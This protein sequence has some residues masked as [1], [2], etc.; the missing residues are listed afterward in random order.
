MFDGWWTVLW[1][2][3]ASRS[4]FTLQSCWPVDN[5]S[6]GCREKHLE[7]ANKITCELIAIPFCSFFGDDLKN[8][9]LAP[10]NNRSKHPF[11]WV[12]DACD[13]Q[14][15]QILNWCWIM[16]NWSDTTKICVCVQDGTDGRPNDIFPKS[17]RTKLKSLSLFS[18]R[19][20]NGR[21][22]LVF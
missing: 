17:K 14:K 5:S 21:L 1:I 20:D 4:P 19:L 15:A 8:V 3:F 22:I 9:V 2:W 13:Q 16:T 6:N 11:W 7:Q 18:D 10:K 12:Y